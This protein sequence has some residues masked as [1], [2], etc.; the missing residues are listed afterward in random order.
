MPD[1]INQIRDLKT[2]AAVLLLTQ[3][4]ENI[5]D[6]ESSSGANANKKLAE[7]IALCQ[8]LVYAIA[9][10]ELA[11]SAALVSLYIS[12]IVLPLKRLSKNSQLLANKKTILPPIGD[13]ETR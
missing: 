2:L 12:K 5:L 1:S 13:N 7:T 6:Y 4:L 10:V 3:K 9:A 11:L 8:N